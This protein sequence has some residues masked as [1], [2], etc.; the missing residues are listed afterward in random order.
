ML[1]SACI[2]EF[3]GLL[4]IQCFKPLQ[5]YCDVCQDNYPVLPYYCCNCHCFPAMAKVHLEN[6]KSVTMSKLEVG[7]RVQTGT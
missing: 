7:D 1:K 3:A 4:F 5:E 2:V 6:G